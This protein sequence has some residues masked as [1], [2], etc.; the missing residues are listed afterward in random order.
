VRS[1]L[2]RSFAAVAAT[3]L[4]VA[5]AAPAEASLRTIAHWRV[6]IS[7][8]VRHDWTLLDSTPCR[9]SGSGSVTAHFASTRPA[10]ITIADNGYGPGDFSWGGG[11]HVR[12][13]ITGLDARTQNPPAPGDSCQN[14]E[15]VPDTR[16]CG[17]RPLNDGLVAE[18]V[19]HGSYRLYDNG[20]FG[21]A[22]TPPD[23]I[24]DCELGSFES[25]A[26]IANGGSPDSQA[27]PLP[28]YPTAARLASRHRK[29]V[30][31]AFQRHR[32]VVTAETTRQVR[33]VF[34]RVGT[35]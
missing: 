30:V 31:S 5:L 15:P 22:L 27:L 2:I 1:L 12:G 9:P 17:T 7:G 16:A 6:T 3:A 19:K 33:I 28:G 24:P 35:H 32:F 13:S 4:S 8:S 21:N 26:T 25:F 10:R 18:P 14:L 34:T 23:G 20:N 11:F 29:I